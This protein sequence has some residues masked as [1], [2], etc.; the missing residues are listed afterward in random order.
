[1]QCMKINNHIS[2]KNLKKIKGYIFEIF[3]GN[4]LL[5]YSALLNEIQSKLVNINIEIVKITNISELSENDLNQLLNNTNKERRLQTFNR[6]F[7]NGAILWL[8]KKDNE[9]AGYI[10]SINSEPGKPYFFPLLKEDVLL[11]DAEVFAKYRGLG[12]NAIL[13]EC[14]LIELQKMGKGRAFLQTKEWNISEINSLKKTTFKI[15]GIAK[16]KTKGKENIVIWYNM[17]GHDKFFPK[18]L[19]DEIK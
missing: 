7:S 3:K 1:M 4:R 2:L 9:V 11:F 19:F 10:W 12:I 17:L 15:I 16:R 18:T 6:R 13:T 5:I 8:S 14:V